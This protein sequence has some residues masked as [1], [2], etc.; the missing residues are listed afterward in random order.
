MRESSKKNLRISIILFFL[1]VVFLIMNLFGFVI[2][3]QIKH[4]EKIDKYQEFLSLKH[5]KDIIFYNLYILDSPVYTYYD[6]SKYYLINIDNNLQEIVDI[7]SVNYQ[8]FLNDDDISDYELNFGYTNESFVVA[9]VKEEL[10][11]VYDLKTKE[12]LFKYERDKV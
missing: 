8:V 6:E 4:Q 2:G 1:I 5:N 11:Y 9:F 7:N 12:L 10:E 3:P